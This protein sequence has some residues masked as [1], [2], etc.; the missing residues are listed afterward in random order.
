MKRP[1]FFAAVLGAVLLCHSEAAVERELHVVGVYQ[2]AGHITGQNNQGTATIH[3][4]RPE[5]SITLF[6][7][8]YDPIRWQVT[9]GVGTV[10]E[11]VFL[12]GY[13]DQEVEGLPEGTPVTETTYEGG[14]AYLSI[15][16]SL[17]D[18]RTL[19]SIPLIEQRTGMTIS[20][21]HGTYEAPAEAIVIDAIQNDPRLASSWPQPV[22]PDELPSLRFNLSLPGVGGSGDSERTRC[23]GRRMAAH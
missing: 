5:K 19:G 9:A 4:D 21:F 3:V 16:Y 15:G 6:L 17:D 2:G 20:S 8:S 12:D 7:S 14:G 18:P 23:R 11:R 22:P 1:I 13:Y 10:I